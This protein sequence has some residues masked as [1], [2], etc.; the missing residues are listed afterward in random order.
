MLSSEGKKLME[1]KQ[2]DP[3]KGPHLST[4]SPRWEE[5]KTFTLHFLGWR[6]V[7]HPYLSSD[8]VRSVINQDSE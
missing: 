7:W 3:V 6:A 2:E 8:Y 1:G 5:V 4:G